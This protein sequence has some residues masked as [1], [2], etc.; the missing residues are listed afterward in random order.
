M[1]IGKHFYNEK[2]VIFIPF[3]VKIIY[4]FL[5]FQGDYECDAPDGGDMPENHIAAWDHPSMDYISKDDENIIFTLCQASDSVRMSNASTIY[6][7]DEETTINST[8]LRPVGAD[9]ENMAY[10]EEEEPRTD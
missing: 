3:N 9:H 5:L 10:V 1:N 4:F 7:Q 8:N 6:V 2:N